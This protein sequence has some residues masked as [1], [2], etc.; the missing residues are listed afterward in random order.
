[1]VKFH[2]HVESFKSSFENINDEKHKETINTDVSIIYSQYLGADA[3]ML[4]DLP[5]QQ[6]QQV[7]DAICPKSGQVTSNCFDE[8]QSYVLNLLQNRY[9]NGFLAS[10]YYKKYLLEVYLSG[11]LSIIDILKTHSVLCAFLEYLESLEDNHGQN[12]LEFIINI[13]DYEQVYNSSPETLVEDAMIIYDKY[14]S[15][16][17]TNNLD[18][19]DDIRIELE[20]RI[21]TESGIPDSNAFDRAYNLACSQLHEVGFCFSCFFYCWFQHYISGFLKSDVFQKIVSNLSVL[22]E[23]DI[24]SSKDL[25]SNLENQQTKIF[26][27][28][29][30]RRITNSR[31]DRLIVSGRN[32]ITSDDGG[33]EVSSQCS[34]GSNVF[35]GH[36]LKTGR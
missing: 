29:S 24:D 10:I 11:C 34:N 31:N 2:L 1:M 30:P 25:R 22:I 18:F 17:A 35:I 5:K 32:S 13:R 6:K 21:C 19:G 3:P 8:V 33:D 26:T 20:S 9:Y 4:L 27:T 15:M 12:C 7:I 36:N 28:P 23:N 14:F 16:Q